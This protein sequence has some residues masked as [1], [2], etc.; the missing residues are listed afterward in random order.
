MVGRYRN[1]EASDGAKR[2]RVWGVEPESGMSESKASQW[3]WKDGR[4]LMVLE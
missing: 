4:R 3:G 1:I 2:N